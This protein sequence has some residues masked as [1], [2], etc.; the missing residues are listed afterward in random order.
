[1]LIWNSVFITTMRDQLYTG[2]ARMKNKLANV[3]C[4]TSN[5]WK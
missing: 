5:Y 1:M 3:N 2:M 4:S